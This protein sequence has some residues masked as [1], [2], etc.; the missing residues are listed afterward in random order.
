MCGIAGIV[1]PT[2]PPDPAE[3]GRMLD[4]I[5]HRGPNDHGMRI[6]G[7]AGIGMRRLSIIDLEGGHQPI[8]NEDGTVWVVSNGEIYNFRQLRRVL[9]GRGHRFRT[10]SDTEVLVHAYEEY[11]V[12]FLEHIEGMFALAIWDETRHRLVVARDRLGIKPLYYHQGADGTLA[13]ASEAKSLLAGGRVTAALDTEGLQDYLAFGYAMA[14]RTIFRSI[15]KLAPAQRMIWEGGSCRRATYWQVSDEVDSDRSEAAWVELIRAELERV[16]RDHMVS[17][18]PLGAFL[19]GGI[20]SSAIVALM[21]GAGDEPVNTYA[22]GYS[23]DAVADYYNELPFAR[24]VAG[25]YGT[26]HREIPVQP[27]VADLLPR[28]MWHL[29]EP[30]SDTA[31]LTTYLVSQLAAESVTV[32]MSGVGG[33]ELFG[34]YTRHLGHHYTE[35]YHRIPRWARRGVVEPLA[36]VLPSGR[37]NRLLDLARYAKQFVRSDHLTWD[38]QY[39]SYLQIQDDAA[40]ARLNPAFGGLPDSFDAITASVRAQDPMLQLLQVDLA[41]QM[42]EA[43]L[44][45]SDKMTMATSLECRVPLLDHRLVELA[46]GIPAGIKVKQG[47]LKHVLKR[48]VADVL[49]PEVVKRRKRGFGAPVGD[50]MQRELAPLRA[51]LLSR[52]TVERRGVLAWPAVETLCEAHDSRREDYTDALMVLMNLEIWSRI[53]LD[54]ASHDDVTGELGERL[55]AA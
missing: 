31:P 22:I 46:A 17:D 30:I 7:G 28:L 15:H 18:V 24:Q 39:R 1:S 42:P 23:G 3:L 6:S 43:L 53:F 14:P 44:L 26:R 29:E 12:D 25:H 50:W 33:D 49:P 54:G 40:L 38:Q 16:V 32:I 5:V 36:R 35:R 8:P 52:E 11:G 55:E 19:S 20:D 9:E 41:T 27:N 21:S 13:F 51:A 48:A 47:R 34:G 10:D 4:A 2:T 45:L 37:N